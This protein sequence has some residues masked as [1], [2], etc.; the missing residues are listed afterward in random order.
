MVDVVLYLVNNIC[1]A[2]DGRVQGRSNATGALDKGP[3]GYINRYDWRVWNGSG[4][5]QR[6]S[7]SLNNMGKGYSAEVSDF[8]QYVVIRAS[9]H[10]TATGKGVHKTFAVV[11]DNPK[12]GDG[13]VFNTSTKWRTISNVDQAASYINSTIRSMASHCDS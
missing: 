13:K 2:G 3:G 11:F 12:I 1:E 4:F 7:A 6:I 5:G 8:G 10:N 9:Y